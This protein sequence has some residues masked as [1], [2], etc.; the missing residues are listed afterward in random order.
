MTDDDEIRES[1][2]DFIHEMWADWMVYLFHYVSKGEIYHI[3]DGDKV[4]RW[5]RQMRTSY[6]DLPEAEKQSD[7]DLADKLRKYFDDIR[8]NEEPS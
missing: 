6:R 5:K 4:E 2:A 7:R 3:I 1:L 8:S